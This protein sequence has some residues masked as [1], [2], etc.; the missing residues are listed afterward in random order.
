ML[1]NW[2]DLVVNKI[3][4]LF[5]GNAVSKTFICEIDKLTQWNPDI[6]IG[7][8]IPTQYQMDDGKFSTSIPAICPN[9]NIILQ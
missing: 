9:K 4:P 6:T 2:K 1:L 8:K 3:N 5:G 7:N